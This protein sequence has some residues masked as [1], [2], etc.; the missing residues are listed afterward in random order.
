MAP[1]RVPLAHPKPDMQAFL[2]AMDGRK[3]PARPPLVEYIVDNTVMRPIVTD[4]LGRPWVEP[5]AITEFTGGQ[6][7]F[8]RESRDLTHRWLDNQIAFWLHM[9]YDFIRIESCPPLPAR[10]ILTGDTARGSEGHDRAWQELHEGPIRTWEDFEKYPWPQVS[11]RDFYTHQY[12]CKHLPEGMG[13]IS[14][15][16]G[17]VFE[18]AS[19]LMGYEHLCYCLVDDPA[20]VRAVADKLGEQIQRYNEHLCQFDKL[21]VILQGEDLG[22]NTQT[23][24]PPDD[25]RGYFLPWH[26]KYVQLAHQHGKRYYLHS[27]GKVDAIM[28]DLIEDVGIDGKHSFQE[29]VQSVRDIKQRYGKRICLLG[30]VDVDRLTSDRPEDLRTYVREIIDTCAPGGRF[31]IGSG[32]S[33]PSYVPVENYLTMLDEAL[34]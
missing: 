14:C 5:G 19:R 25:I 32:N 10:P 7:D 9:G 3:V 6:M 33:I 31:A 18:H 16:A 4:L 12:I 2:D 13:L 29:G 1:Y 20:L 34:R 27:C 28:E 21:A 26:K 8:S 11:E 22:F 30:G 15:H 24:I 17:G 23:L